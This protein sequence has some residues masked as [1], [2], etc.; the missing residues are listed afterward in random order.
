MNPLVTLSS[1]SFF[2][3]SQTIT[4][5]PQLECHNL[6]TARRFTAHLAVVAPTTA[7]GT[8]VWVT[9]R[10]WQ[11]HLGVGQSHFRGKPR[12]KG[13]RSSSAACR[14]PPPASGTAGFRARKVET[15]LFGRPSTGNLP[16]HRLC[17]V[18][19]PTPWYCSQR[20]ARPMRDCF[21]I[22]TRGREDRHQRRLITHRDH[23][24]TTSA[25]HHQ[26][27]GR[28]AATPAFPRARN[29]VLA[30]VTTLTMFSPHEDWLFVA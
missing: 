2:T 28:V 21:H 12:G 1:A 22:D 27:P 19:L 16:V 9:A 13:V 18:T 25:R 14:D 4:L 10:C 20:K 17:G 3:I 15:S 5:M 8:P 24:P 23:E 6:L 11:H 26:I 29:G 7:P 30:P